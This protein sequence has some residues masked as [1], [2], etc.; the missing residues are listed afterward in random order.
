MKTVLQAVK[1]RQAGAQATVDSFVTFKKARKR[2]HCA[3]SSLAQKLIATKNSRHFAM[4]TLVSPPKKENQLWH[5]EMT[6][7]FSG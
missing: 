3:Q 7:V 1:I 4:P 6:A 5:R 2:L